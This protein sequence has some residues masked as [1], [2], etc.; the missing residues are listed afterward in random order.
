MARQKEENEDNSVSWQELVFYRG[1]TEQF[2]FMGAPRVAIM[3]NGLIGFLFIVN[4]HFWYIIPFNI[5][6]HIGCVYLSKH[7]DQFFDC[8]KAYQN[9]KNSYTT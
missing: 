2:L 4:F 1:L 3:L 9:K 8:L 5:I 6:F 7:D